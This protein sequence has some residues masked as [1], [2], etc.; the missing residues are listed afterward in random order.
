MKTKVRESDFPRSPFEIDENELKHL[1][2][3]V[4]WRILRMREGRCPQ[5]GRVLETDMRLCIR[6]TVKQREKGRRRFGCKRRWRS[7]SYE[8]E[9]L[10]NDAEDDAK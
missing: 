5:C 1:D 4:R 8:L 10:I 3:R 6:C 9:K 2:R 7:R